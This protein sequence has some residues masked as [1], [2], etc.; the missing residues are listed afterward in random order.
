MY[1]SG[2]TDSVIDEHGVLE[3]GTYLLHKPFTQDTLARKVREV[4]DGPKP[5]LPQP[6]ADSGL[7][8]QPARA[9]P[10]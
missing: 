2:Y 1:M 10:T 3:P 7:A 4:L 8:R 9:E 6:A 5:T